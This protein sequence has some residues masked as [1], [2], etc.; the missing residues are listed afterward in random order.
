MTTYPRRN[1]FALIT[2]VVSPVSFLGCIFSRGSTVDGAN[3]TV[4]MAGT[5]TEM[6]RRS[7]A[8]SAISRN[9]K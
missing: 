9:N 7:S 5:R 1:V 4:N 6:A 8:P 2:C 3:V